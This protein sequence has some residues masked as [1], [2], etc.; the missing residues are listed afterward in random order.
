MASIRATYLTTT[1]SLLLHA[2]HLLDY[3]VSPTRAKHPTTTASLVTYG[4][5][6]RNVSIDYSVSPSAQRLRGLLQA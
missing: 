4:F 3:N 2:Q 6:T 5:D 1:V